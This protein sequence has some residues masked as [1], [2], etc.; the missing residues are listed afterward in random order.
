MSS[1]LV[2]AIAVV[3]TVVMAT[4][5]FL[6]WCLFCCYVLAG[7]PVG[8]VSS[9]VVKVMVAVYAVFVVLLDVVDAVAAAVLAAVAAHARRRLLSFQFRFV[10]VP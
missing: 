8:V 5:R 9:V 7:A 3:V 2:V 1:V 6:E 4:C 10:R